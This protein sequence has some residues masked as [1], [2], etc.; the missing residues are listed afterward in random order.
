[1]RPV[2]HRDLVK[3]DIFIAQFQNSLGHE[4]RLLAA[5]IQRNH[6]R[7]CRVRVADRL[8]IFFELLDVGFNRGI[9]DH[10]NLRHAPVVHLNLKNLRVRITFR[11]L[12]NILEIGAPP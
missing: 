3:I 12:E 11:K 10:E 7:L 8:Q 2:K 5:V 9:R 1:M 4:L 6:R